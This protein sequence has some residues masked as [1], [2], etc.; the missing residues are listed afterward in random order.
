MLH[1]QFEHGGAQVLQEWVRAAVVVLGRQVAHPVRAER[2][3]D[4]LLLV[5]LAVQDVVV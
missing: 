2:I 1:F 3:V 4:L 5:Q